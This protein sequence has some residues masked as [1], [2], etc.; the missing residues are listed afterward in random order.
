MARCYRYGA[1]SKRMVLLWCVISVFYFVFF[2]VSHSFAGAVAD[3]AAPSE[4]LMAHEFQALRAIKGHFDGGTWNDAVDK[5]QGDKHR[6]MQ[7]ALTRILQGGYGS[8]QVKALLGEPDQVLRA[9]AAEYRQVV[10]RAE[11]QG[12]PVGELWAYHWRGAHDQ[13]IIALEQDKVS[14]GGW[15]LAWE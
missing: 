3:P 10:E 11:W 14:A 9:P 15:L 7:Q 5:W 2:A 8:Q 13:L 6:L 12:T 1:L 4:P